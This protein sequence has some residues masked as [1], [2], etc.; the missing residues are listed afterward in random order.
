L[1]EHDVV[2]IVPTQGSTQKDHTLIIP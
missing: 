2:M 1:F